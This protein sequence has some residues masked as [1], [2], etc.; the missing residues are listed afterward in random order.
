V[1]SLI[2]TGFEP[3]A[4]P[5]S[6]KYGTA[7]GC[8]TTFLRTLELPSEITESLAKWGNL[9]VTRL[10]KISFLKKSFWWSGSM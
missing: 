5:G 4:I 3:K 7:G 9:G 8:T 10:S 2:I 6:T 1:N